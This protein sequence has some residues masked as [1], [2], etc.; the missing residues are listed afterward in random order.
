MFVSGIAF[1]SFRKVCVFPVKLFLQLVIFSMPLAFLGGSIDLDP[2][3]YKRIL[4]VVLLFAIF[5]LLS[6]RTIKSENS[7]SQNFI[8]VACIGAVIG[9]VSGLIG[10]GGGII[11]SPILLFWVGQISKKLQRSV[12]C[13]FFKFIGRTY[14]FSSQFNRAEF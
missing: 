6:N 4:A 13:L 14:G 7:I 5:R 1:W 12:H 10:I 11:L 9:F 2:L 3:W 8:L